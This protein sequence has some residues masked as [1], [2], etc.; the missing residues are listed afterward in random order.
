MID[1]HTYNCREQ[2]ECYLTYRRR[3]A[4]EKEKFINDRAIKQTNAAWIAE[5]NAAGGVGSAR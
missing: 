3:M 1:V 4:R 5:Y 2:G